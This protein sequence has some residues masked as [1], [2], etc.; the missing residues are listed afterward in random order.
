MASAN[1][2]FDSENDIFGEFGEYVKLNG[3]P[4]I[5]LFGASH[6]NHLKAYLN[7]LGHSEEVKQSFRNVEYLAVGGA[8]WTK[9]I[10]DIK[11]INLSQY[12]PH[13]GNQPS[14]APRD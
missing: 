14:D 1:V 6:W 10:D 3:G 13:L 12:Q 2:E 11:G 4:K 7:Y 5:V 8:T 9:C